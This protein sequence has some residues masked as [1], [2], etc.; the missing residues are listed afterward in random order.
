LTTVLEILFCGATVL[1]LLPAAFLCMEIVFASTRHVGDPRNTGERG[2]LAIIMPAHDEASIIAATLSSVI[3]QLN[4]S[5]QIVVVADNCSDDTATIASGAGA[6]VIV[7]TDT[8]R[9]GKGYALDFGVRHL[10][11]RAPNTVIIIDADCLVGE[12]SI[13]RLARA[14]NRTGGPVQALYL[15]HASKHASARTRIAEFALAVKNKA[16][17]SGLHRLGLPCQ[18][19][20]TGMAFPWK[21]IRD[22]DLAT[23][24]IAEDLKLGVDLARAGTPPTF[25]PDALVTSNFPESTEGMQTQR[26]R[27]E[28]GHLGVIVR[29]APRLLLDGILRMD[30]KLVAMAF[31]LSVPPLALL[32]L[33]LSAVWIASAVFWAFTRELIPLE[34]AS[35]AAVLLVL[36]VMSS[37]LRF[38]RHIISLSDLAQALFYALWKI[39]LYAKFLV[40]RQLDW[41]RSK[42]DSDGPRP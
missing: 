33:E 6:E 37:W 35:L 8:S 19:M 36:A 25:C 10:E 34:I 11:H 18:L 14:C 30:L 21:C 20:G 26:T 4:A 15:M 17:P 41:V 38:G 9:R 29:D 1:V 24:H 2:R 13:D 28:H 7:R 23:G 39:P 31:D 22:A 16:R 32:T 3:P 40:A 12:G 5:D 42:R 27:W